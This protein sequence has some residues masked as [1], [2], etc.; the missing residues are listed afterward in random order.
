M[1]FPR[2]QV[3]YN[4]LSRLKSQYRHSLLHNNIPPAAVAYAAVA[5]NVNADIAVELDA[6]V[7]EV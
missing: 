4:S 3:T 6:S 5:A 2:A 7:E 1:D